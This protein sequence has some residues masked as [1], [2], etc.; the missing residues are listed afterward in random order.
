[1]KTSGIA[2][3]IEAFRRHPRPLRLRCGV[4]HY[5]WG[6]RDYIPDLLGIRNKTR[7]PYAELWI[8]AHDD[9]ASVASIAGVDVPLNSLIE[10][11]A[12][13]V[14]GRDVADRFDRQ[15]P[16][17]MKILSAGQPLS[18]QAH[19]NTRQAEE[20]FA[21]ENELG[22]PLEDTNRNYRD[23]HH[24]PELISALTDFFALRGFRAVGEIATVFA[25]IPEFQDL[26][27]RFRP[28]T[29]S[30]ITLYTRIMRM[31]QSEVDG[32]LSPL[33]VRLGEENQK[34][35]FSKKQPEFWVL[36]ADN[37]FSPP[38]H[39]DR[40]IFS[41]FLLNLVHLRPGQAMISTPVP[42]R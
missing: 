35:A 12:D 26:A 21:R 23:P 37:V 30:L 13:A 39:K 4:Q 15:L 18:I 17:L 5:Q 27:A 20:G 1:M 28:T 14:I 2:P 3:V 36:R 34:Q 11:A 10:D 31:E 22:I 32:I 25:S 6:G 8:G 33:V 42:S 40:G 16:F 9:L 29:D 19:P 7:E 41:I 38:E 24:K